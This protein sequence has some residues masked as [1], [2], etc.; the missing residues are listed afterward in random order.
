MNTSFITSSRMAYPLTS[1]PWHAILA[2]RS[3]LYGKRHFALKGPVHLKPSLF[4]NS[5]FAGASLVL[6]LLTTAACGSTL[7]KPLTADQI[8][9]K[10]NQA[11]LKDAAFTMN[12]T[13]GASGVSLN[14][15]GNGKFTQ[16]PARSQVILQ[17][18]LL[19]TETTV[20]DITADGYD[21]VKTSPATKYSKTTAGTDSTFGVGGGA[22]NG[23]GNLKNPTLVGIET[24]DGYQTYHLHGTSAAPTPEPNASTPAS[25]ANEDLWVKTQ[26]FYPVKVTLTEN[27]TTAGQSTTANITLTFTSWN[28][29][30]TV[31]VPPPSEV[32]NG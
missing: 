26:N 14:F 15:T 31:A 24:V 27:S 21:Y 11:N 20:D 17:G 6:C 18:N 9:Q 23:I 12:L 7:T 5:F 16:S 4:R 2:T 1:F 8:A 10:A 13:V 3:R 30:L 32:T 19:G 22:V 25:P 28:T 29:G